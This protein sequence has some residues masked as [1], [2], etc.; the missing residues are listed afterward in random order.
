MAV[1]E[2]LKEEVSPCPPHIVHSLSTQEEGWGSDQAGVR[3]EKV[4]NGYRLQGIGITSLHS[5][6]WRTCAKVAANG[7]AHTLS[8]SQKVL[9]ELVRCFHV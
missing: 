7:F 9:T 2:E 6:K 4:A 1:A 3:Q 5:T 8:K